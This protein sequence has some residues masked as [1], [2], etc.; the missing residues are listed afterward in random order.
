MFSVDSNGI[1]L[2]CDERTHNRYAP[3][4]HNFMC[5]KKST[6]DV[7]LK[8][9]DFEVK[10]PINGNRR[11]FKPPK[12][13]YKQKYN[14]T[15][16]ALIIDETLDMQIRESWSFLRS[17]LRKWIVYDLPENSEIGMIL[18]NE[19]GVDKILEFHHLGENGNRDTIASFFP[20][21]AIDSRQKACLSCAIIYYIDKINKHAHINP[22]GKNIII[23]IAPGMDYST[24]IELL[25]DIVEKSAI[26]IITINYPSVI[27]RSPLDSLTWISNGNAFTVFEKKYNFEK[28][29]LETYFELTNILNHIAISNNCKNNVGSSREI[30]RKEII[31]TVY[32]DNRSK[33]SKRMSRNMTGTFVLD[34][35]MGMP[36]GFFVYTHNVEQPLIES[37]SLVSP[38]GKVYSKSSDHRLLVKQLTVSAVINETGSWT[39]IIQRLIG[40]QQSHFI[41]V[42]SCL[43][44]IV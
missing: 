18:V 1:N 44:Y 40:N 9:K 21:S 38:S 39:Y 4:K 12:F 26:E 35:T 2:F 22:G 31:N 20:F 8:H 6:I 43:L 15:R 34:I 7:I 42:I 13:Y 24:N 14:Y 3:N 16:Y 10:T 41:Q 37:I 19:T 25:K 5:D 23:I 32:N 36:A 33:I 27:R 28:S 29:L 30:H 17:A 11:E